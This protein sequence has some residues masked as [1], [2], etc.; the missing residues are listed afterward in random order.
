MRTA[1][2][3]DRR[4]FAI[5]AAIAAIAVLGLV[6]RLLAARGGLWLDEAWS[7]VYAA[8]A[9]TPLGVFVSINHDNNH[10]LN[11]LWLQTIG[12]SAPPLLARAPSIIAGTIGILAAAAIGARRNTATA[13]TAAILFA[14][15]PALVHYGAEAR[16]YATMTLAFLVALLIVDRWL[17][18]PR[19]PPPRLAL[20]A[21]AVF[22][23]FSQLTMVFGLLAIA[24][25]V[26]ARLAATGWRY[27]ALDRTFDLMIPALA[28]TLLVFTLVF[29]AAA[30]S[31]TGM[32]V[33]SNEDFTFPG[34]LDAL[35][36]LV[37]TVFGAPLPAG[38]GAALVMLLMPLAALPVAALRGRIGF[39]L[40]AIVAFPLMTVLLQ[41]PNTHYSRYYLVAG[42]AMLLFAA[43]WLGH[44]FAGSRA[45]RRAAAAVICALLLAASLIRDIRQID[46]AHA[47]PAL[48]VAAMR[49]AAPGGATILLDNIRSSA[50]L[51][52]AAASAHYTLDIR[53]TC[54]AAPFFLLDATRP[55]AFPD[56]VRRCGATYR[57]LLTRRKHD[58]P[59]MDWRLYRR[60]PG[61]G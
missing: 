3:H 21:L 47:D 8:R 6:L 15:S 36:D 34:F 22:G 56:K 54:P 55:R 49:A 43:D 9:R 40:F 23:L 16:G 39:Y 19:A 42:I 13:L 52:A 20:G 18:D 14:V 4:R 51:Q 58:L 24:G 60:Q 44:A 10:H 12:L 37:M 46:N 33:G 28:A 25:W 29:G 11:S 61:N 27:K 31:K 7:A 35:H 59:G 1:P 38:W 45:T 32:Q 41:V 26:F 50:V 57:A 48:P 30:L 53:E 5:A 17:D 2:L